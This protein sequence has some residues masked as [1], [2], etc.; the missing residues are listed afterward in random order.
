MGGYFSA[1]AYL[2]ERGAGSGSTRGFAPPQYARSTSGAVPQQLPL[3]TEEAH[4]GGG[5]TRREDGECRGPRA[6]LDPTGHPLPLFR[7]RAGPC[8]QAQGERMA[9]SLLPGFWLGG[10][11]PRGWA[12][13]RPG[14]GEACGGP[15]PGGGRRRAGSLGAGSS[16]LWAGRRLDRTSSESELRSRARI[17]P[18]GGG[19]ARPAEIAQRSREVWSGAW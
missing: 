2:G 14:P 6:P 5:G 10:G 15:I 19:C 17:S 8:A 12:L 18:R 16:L 9:L 13:G 1:L 3:V 7:P 4:G 11:A